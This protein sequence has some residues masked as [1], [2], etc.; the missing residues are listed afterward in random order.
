MIGSGAGA[1]ADGVVLAAFTEAVV[2]G[3]VT[4]G[5]SEATTRREVRT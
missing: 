2:R 3:R 1:G 5:E 4:K